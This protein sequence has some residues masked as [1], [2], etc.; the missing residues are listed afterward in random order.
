ML[1]IGENINATGKKVAEAIKTKDISFLQELASAQIAAD[2]LDINVGRGEGSAGQE[3]EDMKWLIGIIC[4]VSDKPLV[5]DSA[6][7][8]V[9]EAGLKQGTSLRDPLVIASRRRSNQVAMIN[10][11]N[12]EKA[13]LEA[14]GPLVAK[15]QVDVIALAMDDNG[16][17]SRAE[18]RIE[19]CDRILEGLSHYSIPAEKVYFD[20]LVLPIGVDT[21]QGEVTLRTLEQIKA[22]YPEAKTVVG[23][24]N[25]SYGLPERSI[26][27]EAFLL[28]LMSAGLD[29]VI[30]N[31]LRSSAIGS[32]KV[33]E[34]LLGK[35]AHCKEYLKAYRKGL[36]SK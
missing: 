6:N 1:I 26:I 35:D 36:F 3:I 27:N 32:I 34:M 12:A 15:Y 7:P 20:P 4:E 28:M 8:E 33:G 11:V 30:V 18:E 21:T 14:I 24:S 2:Y 17:S 19:A 13:R 31:P 16:I 23:L 25:I 10:S 5:V 29:A 9:I 22:R